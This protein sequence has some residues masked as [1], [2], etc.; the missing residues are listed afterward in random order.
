MLTAH[1]VD[2]RAVEDGAE[3]TLGPLADVQ[4]S[5]RMRLLGRP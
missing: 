3:G 2:R 5:V 1:V 4:V